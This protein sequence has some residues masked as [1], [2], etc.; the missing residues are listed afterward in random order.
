MTTH[1]HPHLHEL[2]TAS[3]TLGWLGA[4][5]VVGAPHRPL[6]LLAWLMA[7][8]TLVCLVGIV[9][10]DRQLLGL[11]IWDKPLK[12]SISVLIYAV[13]W[14]WLIDRL[15][16]FRRVAWWAGTVATLG[17]AG[18]MVVIIG[19]TVRGETSHFNVTTPLNTALWGAMAMMIAAVW[20]AS[21]VVCALLFRNPSADPAQVWAIRGG[22][23]LSV[24]GMALGMLMTTPTEAQ[25]SSE[26]MDVVGAHT[27]GLADGGPGLPVLG[28]STVGGDLRIPHFIGMHA[29]Q[30]LPLLLIVLELLSRR[31][32]VL[33]DPTVR[34]R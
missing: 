28:W 1:Q 8:S 19:Q 11:N 12:F 16:R 10:D 31:V 33:T 26:T 18:E 14:S 32:A 20:V 3:P 6:R 27:V 34:R 4:D 23:L 9:V 30:A 24:V 7:A 21:L 25:L 15:Q 17:L 2:V 13:T 29:L 5:H 22:A